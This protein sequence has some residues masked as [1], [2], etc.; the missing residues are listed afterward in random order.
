ML[1][2]VLPILM[3]LIIW[4]V[5]GIFHNQ[6]ADVSGLPMF[7]VF[8]RWITKIHFLAVL[9]GLSLLILEAFIWNTFINKQSLLRQSSYF[10]AMFY[11][12]LYSCRHN[13]INFYPALIAS[14]FLILSLK[15]LTESYKKEKALSEAFDAGVFIGI[16]ALVYFP[17]TVFLVFLWIGLLTMRSLIWREWLISLIGFLLPFIFSLVYYS[18]FYTPETFWHEKLVTA[19]GHYKKIMMPGWQQI[20]LIAS[21]AVTALVSAFFFLG[22]F[23]DNV[24]KNQK[25]SA[26]IGWFT[27]FAA[28]SLIASPRRDACAFSLLALPFSFIFSN[29][30]VRTKKKLIPEILFMILIV[31][32]I[33]NV[34]F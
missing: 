31:A 20:I 18:I 15:R 22:K 7:D 5:S 24:V 28:I 23:T 10:P 13:L 33:V 3:A 26:L 19:I 11:L 29:Y 17:A 8:F 16:A 25:I 32:I 21:L 34:F 9:L 4:I 27:L 14:L 30:F 2:L 12:F 6:S 1:S